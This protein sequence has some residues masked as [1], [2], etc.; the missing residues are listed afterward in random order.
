VIRINKLGHCTLYTGANDIGMGSD[1]AM[2]AIAAEELGLQMKDITTVVSDTHLLP[3]I[4]APTAAASPSCPA[5][6]A[7][8][9][10]WM[11]R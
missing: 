3:L 9:R 11:P 6:P 2:T 1:T 10:Q 5:M 7:E 8:E 4:P